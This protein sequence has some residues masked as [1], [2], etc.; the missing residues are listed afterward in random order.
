MGLG[1]VLV[2]LLLLLVLLLLLLLL[3]R[4]FNLRLASRC[5]QCLLSSSLWP[6]PSTVFR[7]WCELAWID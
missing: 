5:F 4:I 7:R 3:R 2:L 1:W 6:V